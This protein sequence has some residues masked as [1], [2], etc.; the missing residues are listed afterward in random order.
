MKR[1]YQAKNEFRRVID[2]REI[3]GKLGRWGE[4]IR[5]G[6]NRKLP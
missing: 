5:Y 3:M 2:S 6:S 1:T 4:R